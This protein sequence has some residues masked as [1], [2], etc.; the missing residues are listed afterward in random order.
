[1]GE[2]ACQ[3]F[4]KTISGVLGQTCV[5]ISDSETR[6]ESAKVARVC[7]SSL[8]ICLHA[9]P[10]LLKF[11]LFKTELKVLLA[12]YGNVFKWCIR[13]LRLF[14]DKP[15]E[16]NTKLIGNGTELELKHEL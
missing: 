7:K 14:S 5:R 13:S 8:Q 15:G 6:P 2:H 16:I 11:C 3:K 10:S 4:S 1:M 9:C 12:L